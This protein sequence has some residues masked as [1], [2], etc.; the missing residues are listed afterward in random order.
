MEGPPRGPS[1]GAMHRF[2]LPR[3]DEGV[4]KEIV[5]MLT[6]TFRNVLHR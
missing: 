5:A 2:L 6:K 3:Q 1:N 4:E